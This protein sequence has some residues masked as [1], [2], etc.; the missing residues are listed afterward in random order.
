MFADLLVMGTIVVAKKMEV[1]VGTTNH[2][3]HDKS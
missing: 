1:D 2:T 3:L